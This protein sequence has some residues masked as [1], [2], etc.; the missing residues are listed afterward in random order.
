MIYRHYVFPGQS[1]STQTQ[2]QQSPLQHL[3]PLLPRKMK[4]SETHAQLSF[5][6][7]INAVT[8]AVEADI[9][10]TKGPEA[11]LLKVVYTQIKHNKKKIRCFALL[12]LQ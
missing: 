6:Q 11:A 9:Y 7:T 1:V 10:T 12:K 8:A 5:Q 2:Q 4:L 3:Q